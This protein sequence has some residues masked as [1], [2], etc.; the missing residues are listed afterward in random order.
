MSI[1]LTSLTSSSSM[2]I[3]KYPSSSSKNIDKYPSSSRKD[4]DKY[5][6]SSSKDI[7]KYPSSSSKD[8]AKYPSSSSKC[9]SSRTIRGCS[10]IRSI[11]SLDISRSSTSSANKKKYNIAEWQKGFVGI[12]QEETLEQANKL[13]KAWVLRYPCDEHNMFVQIVVCNRVAVQRGDR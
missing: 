7:D 2:D 11:S 12:L 10:D 13:F 6:S 5:P 9:N 1:F 8:I 4:I 3:D